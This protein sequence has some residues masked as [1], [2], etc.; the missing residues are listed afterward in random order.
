MLYAEIEDLE[1][2][3]PNP[4]TEQKP[5][6]EQPIA[7]VEATV[8]DATSVLAASVKREKAI[9]GSDVELVELLESTIL[10]VDAPDGAWEKAATAIL[11]L[12]SSRAESGMGI[13]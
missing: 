6:V 7:Q 11:K 2:S 1:L 4:M 13:Q 5:A 8:L 12:A 9:K 3:A 10:R